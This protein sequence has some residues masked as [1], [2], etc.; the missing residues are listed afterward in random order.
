MASLFTRFFGPIAGV[1]GWNAGR[2]LYRRAVFR[3][4][5]VQSA[6]IQIP[7]LCIVDWSVVCR[8]VHFPEVLGEV[9]TSN[10]GAPI[11]VDWVARSG[12]ASGW[13]G[14]QQQLHLVDLTATG[15]RCRLGGVRA[16]SCVVILRDDSRIR[17]NQSFNA[18]QRRQQHCIGS[19][20]T[21]WGG[22]HQRTG[23]LGD[24]LLVGFCGFDRLASR[25]PAASQTRP[26]NAG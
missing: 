18:V 1:C 8:E 5:H 23:D 6:G 19:G 20:I 17:T 22:D 25:G 15:R 13:L 11:V 10:G 4:V 14:D 26:I 21:D 16:G 24:I 2:G 9:G 3:T 7:P 12:P